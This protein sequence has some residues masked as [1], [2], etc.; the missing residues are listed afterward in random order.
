MSNDCS[1]AAEVTSDLHSNDVGDQVD[2]CMSQPR[3]TCC[4]FNKYSPYIDC[5]FQLT[6]PVDQSLAGC[7]YWTARTFSFQVFCL[8]WELGS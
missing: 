7:F 1:K 2:R 5:A 8:D 4:G 3:S 6:W